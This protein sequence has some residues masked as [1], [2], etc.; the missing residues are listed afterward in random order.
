ME[1]SRPSLRRRGGKVSSLKIPSFAE[2]RA[3]EAKGYRYIAGIDEVGRGALAGPVMA[4]AVILPLH[5]EAS[6]LGLV[7]DSK[8][9]S[10]AQRELLFHHIHQTALAIGVGLADCEIIDNQGISKATRLAMKLAIDQLSPP[11]EIL[12]IDYLS[13]PEVRLPQKGIVD[14]DSRCFSIAC[15]SIVAKVTRD[16]LMRELDKAY[17]GYKLASH[18][19]YGTKAHLACLYQLGPSPVHRCSFQ[20]VKDLVKK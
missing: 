7:R 6:W 18:K 3:L 5:L 19:G 17:P 14:G 10:P 12:L 15:A 13:L 9:L 16:Q 4:A 20:P 2:E 11:P 8:L 1:N